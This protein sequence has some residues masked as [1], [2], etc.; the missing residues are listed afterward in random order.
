MSI[1]VRVSVWI[2]GLLVVISAGVAVLALMQK[3]T[4]QGQFETLRKEFN[5]DQNQIAGMTAQAKTLQDKIDQLGGQITQAQQDKASLQSQYDQLKQKSDDITAQLQQANSDRDDWKN[6]ADTVSKERDQLMDKL[7]HQPVKIV[8]K[9]KTRTVKVPAA[10]PASAAAPDL[11]T[12]TAPDVTTQK[13]E[14]YW[15]SV[16]RQ[17]AALQVELEKE[18][19]DLDQAALQVVTLKKQNTDLETQVKQL[20]NEKDEIVQKIKYGQDLADN[21]SVDLARSRNDQAAVNDRADRLKG[22]N[23]QLL[24]QIRQLDAAKL[25]LEQNVSRLTDDKESLQKKLIE[26]ESVIQGRIDDIWKIKASLDKKL[27]ENAPTASSSNGSS[28]ELPPI[29]VNAPSQAPAASAAP[30]GTATMTNGKTEG[31]I[32]SINEPNNFVIVDLGQ[33][34]SPVAIGSILKVYRDSNQVA[35]LQV[36]QVRRDI[37]AADIKTKSAELKVGDIVRIAQ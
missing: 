1:A 6:R 30:A 2:L 32:I 23:E 21:L 8:Y 35:S 22:E 5:N 18:K 31:S 17:K 27:A 33:E 26:T 36:I 34:N 10:A 19:A 37:C 24:S 12:L 9:Y 29:I 28:M 11:S 14:Y 16:L 4:L 20:A 7:K 15:A 25:Q 3:Q 13:G